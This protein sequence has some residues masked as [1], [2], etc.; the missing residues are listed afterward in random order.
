MDHWPATP[1]YAGKTRRQHDLQLI[2]FMCCLGL[3]GGI[4]AGKSYCPVLAMRRNRCRRR[5]LAREWS[6]GF[7]GLASLVGIRSRHPACRRALDRR[8]LAAKAF[9]DGESRGGFGEPVPLV[10]SADPRSSRRFRGRGCG[11]RYSA[12]VESGMAPLFPL[13]MVVH[14]DI[15]LQVRRLVE[16][17]GSQPTPG[18]G[19]LRRPATNGDVPSPRLA[20]QLQAAQ[21][22]WCA[23]PR[24]RDTRVQPFAHN[25]A[26]RPDCARAGWVGAGGSKLADQARRIVS[27]LKIAC[28]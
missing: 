18:L 1:S 12:T 20:G 8:A 5:V 24:R 6:A 7:P 19:S 26:Q 2:A 17:R 15:E 28:E 27:R 9:R 11:R 14:A 25:L 10:A 4:G 22:V 3:S 16:L 23:G 21:R 13:V